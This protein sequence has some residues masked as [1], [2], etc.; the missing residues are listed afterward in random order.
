MELDLEQGGEA[1]LSA[2]E[3]EAVQEGLADYANGNVMSLKE[4]IDKR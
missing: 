4:F 3:W 2:E 1:E